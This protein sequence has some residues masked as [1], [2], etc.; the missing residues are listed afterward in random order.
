MHIKDNAV[1]EYQIWIVFA[2]LTS[3]LILFVWQRIR[4][5]IVAALML[6]SIGLTGIISVEEIFSGFASP[7]VITVA[8]ALVI[9]KSLENSGILDK[10]EAYL[11]RFEKRPMLSFLLLL[12]LVSLV[13]GFINDIAALAITLPIALSLARSLKLEPSKILIP[14]A[15]A[16]IIG[17]S[18][19]L[20]G[21]ASNI[22][23]GTIAK[24]ELDQ[25]LGIFEFFPVGLALTFAFIVIF[26]LIGK[27]VLPTRTSSYGVEKFE[28]PKYIAE[29]QIMGK[30]KFLD[31]TIGEFEREC[32]GDIEVVRIV[33]ERH[34]RD[35]P[36]S[37][38]RI[39]LGD[40][41]VIRS[42]AEVLQKITKD[43]GLNLIRE[44]A[45][46][47]TKELQVIETVV[48]PSSILIDKTA[49]QIY[50]RDRFNVAL[51]GIARHGSTLT[52]RVDDI[53]IKIG[54]VLLL[55][56]AQADLQNVLQELQCAPLHKRGISLHARAP[57]M[58][59]LVIAGVSIGLT[60]F[61]ILPVEMALAVGAVAMLVLKSISLREAYA[62]IQWP[63]LIL[64][65]S[66]IPFGIAM[67][68]TGADRF[69]AEQIL[70]IGISE[71]IM[72]LAIVF[73]A[74]T[75]LSNVINNVAA[76]VFMAPVALQLSDILGIAGLP[77]LMAVIFGAAVPYLT[78]ISH[79]SN[80]L[81]MEAGGYK[82]TDYLRL[83]IPLTA[84]TAGIVVFLVPILWPFQ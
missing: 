18:L 42:E 16:S 34:E 4:Y 11:L 7:A 8:A 12:L 82:F 79:H 64:I 83:G 43:T 15:Y 20:I 62:A 25:S 46:D 73:I 65:G 30:S 71:P 37:N 14:L 36:H 45:N 47:K 58:L 5:D 19:T 31:K 55:E 38:T 49:R 13:S 21:T 48:L 40:V 41:L 32:E 59:T 69:I 26:L 27:R 75:L 84:V 44:Q 52:K 51:L 68:N 22:V 10:A 78:P 57:P 6:L 33:R 60:A 63:I 76:A 74:T 61:G 50:L 2:I 35:L 1:T 3:G 54:D 9:A 56:V 70:L 72:A 66:I 39:G 29:V 17:G 24:R 80:L 77:M 67:K 81:V 28:L 53:Q 23:M